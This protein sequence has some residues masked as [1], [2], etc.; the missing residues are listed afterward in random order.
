MT[1]P[2]I[3][4]PMHGFGGGVADADRVGAVRAARPEH[5]A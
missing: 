1:L 4:E 3:V 5:G 2:D